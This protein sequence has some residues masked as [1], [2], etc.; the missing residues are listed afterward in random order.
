MQ[1]T[2]DMELSASMPSKS[3]GNEVFELPLGILL[4]GL[5]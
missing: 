4:Q 3:T 2:K 5:M 1:F